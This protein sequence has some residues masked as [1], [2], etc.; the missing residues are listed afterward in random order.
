MSVSVPFVDLRAQHEEVL[1]RH[2]P[3]HV[4]P[5]LAGQRD[6]AEHVGA[7]LEQKLCC[8]VQQHAGEQEGEGGG[9]HG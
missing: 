4:E 6:D 3:R 2:L 5:V 9:G 7:G 8:G 1:R